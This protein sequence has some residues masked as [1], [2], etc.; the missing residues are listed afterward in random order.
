MVLFSLLWYWRDKYWILPRSVHVALRKL[1]LISPGTGPQLIKS[2]VRIVMFQ[3]ALY[4]CPLGH[5][6]TWRFIGSL[7]EKRL[8]IKAAVVEKVDQVEMISGPWSP[9][10]QER[11]LGGHLTSPCLSFIIY[12]TR[13]IITLTSQCWLKAS[14]HS[15]LNSVPD[16]GCCWFSS[17]FRI[18]SAPFFSLL[19]SFFLFLFII[20][21]LLL[22]HLFV[23]H[24]VLMEIKLVLTGYNS[25][26]F[27]TESKS[28][29][30]QK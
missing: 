17:P 22:H 21:S 28:V 4:A 23:S 14:I 16:S 27:F 8:I 6:F 24:E 18:L 1:Y 2:F 9:F 30:F 12:N 5:C 13:I 10:H 26:L 19:F 20:P 25:L 15:A 3:N 11:D 29:T 7:E